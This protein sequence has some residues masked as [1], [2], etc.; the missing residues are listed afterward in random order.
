MTCSE[1]VLFFGSNDARNCMY[2]L[3]SGKPKLKIHFSAIYILYN[4]IFII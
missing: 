4:I 3:I 1:I 2:V